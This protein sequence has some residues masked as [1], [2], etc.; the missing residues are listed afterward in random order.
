MLSTETNKELLPPPVGLLSGGTDYNMW[1]QGFPFS[2]Q[3]HGRE[4]ICQDKPLA[5]AKWLVQNA[6]RA[7]LKAEVSKTYAPV[8]PVGPGVMWSAAC[9]V[10]WMAPHKAQSSGAVAE[11]STAPEYLCEALGMCC[12]WQEIQGTAAQLHGRGSG[13]MKYN[14][15]VVGAGPKCGPSL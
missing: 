10:H 6:G 2:I 12:M 14:P 5:K 8:L 4:L 7:S 1:S 13:T 15:V 3:T 9:G 11:S